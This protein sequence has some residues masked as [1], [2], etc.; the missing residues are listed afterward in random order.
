MKKISMFL[1]GLMM[2]MGCENITDINVNPKAAVNV[3][4]ATLFSN[5]QKNLVD[6]L[7]TPNVNTNIFRLLAQ[8]WTETTYTD[9]SRYDLNTRNIP[10]NFWNSVYLGVLKDLSQAKDLIENDA[11]L[12]PDVK[13]NQLAQI[14]I[15]EV[16]AW[17]VL[18]NTFGDIPYTEALD[19]N[20]T[21]PTY[22]DAKTIYDDLFIKLD[23]A[24]ANISTGAEGLGSGDLIYGDD[25]SAWQK[26]GNSL[27]L[28]MGMTIADS[29]AAKAKTVV[30]QAS[31]NVFTSNADNASFQYLDSPP[32]TNPIWVDL[33][34]SGRNDFVVANTIV[35]KMNSLN[36]PRVGYYFTLAADDTYKGGIYGTSNN[37]ATYSKPSDVIQAQEFEG[38]LL[39]YT[40]VEF[41]L[42]EAVERGFSVGG[43]AESHYNKAIE[44]SIKYWG[45]TTAEV[46]T[47][48]ALPAVAYTT[49]AGTYKQ[50]IGTQKWIA[51]FNRGFE[52]WTE[53]RRLD[54]P[55]LNTVSDPLGSFP[56][57]YTYPVQEQNLNTSN[58][59]AAATAMGG[60]LVTK[61]IFWDV[62]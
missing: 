10:Q 53:Y 44:A 61:K 26:F 54:A 28:R 36:D 8:Q 1:M 12:L 32:N 29:D 62:N 21:Q 18:V 6:V 39:D 51:L 50:K 13:K 14:A 55:T 52:A 35:D 11:S 41:Y 60:D 2:M 48:L 24:L 46:N 38:M 42:A 7:T 33:V 31:A 23:A 27:K 59:N 3:P 17:S 49:A 34:Q 57:R 20:N 47:Y 22:D 15:V 56:L 9:E 19:F 58:Y 30:E 37:F 5:A 25:M 40:E 45:G 16:Y 4:A 43:T